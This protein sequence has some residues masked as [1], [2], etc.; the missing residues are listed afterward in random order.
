[1][2]FMGEKNMEMKFD[3][4]TRLALEVMAYK[5]GIE[6]PENFIDELETLILVPKHCRCKHESIPEA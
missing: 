4:V 1:M 2:N 6:Q 3:Q 5:H